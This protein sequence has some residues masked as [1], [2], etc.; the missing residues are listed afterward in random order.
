MFASY[1]GHLDVVKYLIEE[2]GANPKLE[3]IDNNT[4][5]DIALETGHSEVAEYLEQFNWVS[6]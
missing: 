3:N 1:N 5:Y 4:A 6:I 2:E